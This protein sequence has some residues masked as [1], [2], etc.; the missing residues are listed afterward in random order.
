MAL[1]QKFLMKVQGISEAWMPKEAYMD[2]LAAVPGIF[3]RNFCA[4]AI[5]A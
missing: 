1:A 4:S 5:P 2:V 3:M